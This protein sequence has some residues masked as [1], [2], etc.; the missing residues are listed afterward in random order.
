MSKLKTLIWQPLSTILT[1]LIPILILQAPELAFAQ[2]ESG[3]DE[4]ADAQAEEPEDSDASMLDRIVVTASKR[5]ETL[6]D[7][8]ISMTVVD[9][10]MLEKGRGR[11]LQDMQQLVPNFSMDR[12]G[13]AVLTIRGVGGGGRNIGFDPRAGVYLDGVYIGQAQ[14]LGMPLFDIEQVEVLRGPQGYLFGRN[15]VS[16]AV[17][18]TTRA[19]VS[20]LES[21]VRV[22]GG[23]D[24]TYEGYA[25]VSG[26]ISDRARVKVAASYETRDGYARNLF[27]GED[28]DDLERT[29]LRAQLSVD[30]TQ[31]LS[32]NLY[33]DY[34][35]TEEDNVLGQ[36]V[37]DFFD[38]PFE[39]SLNP[40]GLLPP[41]KVD[42]NTTP[43]VD[44]ELYGASLNLEYAFDGGH[45]L[46]SISAYRGIEQQRQNDTDY[47]AN[48][49]LRI[50]FDDEFDQFSQEIR[51]ASPDSGRLRYLGGLYFLHEDAD[52]DRRATI[53]QDVLTLVPLPPGAPVPFAPFGPAFGLAPGAVVPAIA[54]VETDNFSIFGSLEYDLIES[55]TLN[56][57]LRYTHEEKDL[58]FTLDG[59]QS[60]GFQIGNLDDFRDDRTEDKIDPS[61]SLTWAV[62]DQANIYAKYAR[63][64]K[65]GGWNIDFL[66]V[67][68][69]ATGFDFDS[70]TVDS[71]EIGVKG[72][73]ANGRIRYDLAGFYNEFDDFQ[74]FQF[75]PLGGGAAVLQLRNAAKV[76]TTGIDGSITWL[77]ARGVRLT[78]NFGYVDAEFDRFP[79]GGPDGADLSGNDVPAPDFTAALIAELDFPGELFAGQFSLYAEYSFRDSY[80]SGPSNDPTFERIDSRNLVNTRL[81]YRHRGGHLG[82]GLWVRNLFDENFLNTRG[83]DFI[84]NQFV[85]FGEPRSYGIELR[86]DY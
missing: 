78:G 73:A 7:V 29:S 14:S 46:T 8:P 64:F 84:G 59:S 63:G 27:N 10:D 48:D 5:A 20:E 1:V 40:D 76:E 66:N 41:R 24:G 54:N 25:I 86:Y 35:D 80:F 38:T 6:E 83:R 33:V 65:S 2:S 74:V 22:T 49:L 79:N 23:N 34:T 71:Y 3:A 26:P 82:A 85:Q 15:T 16:G 56:V 50:N 57:G 72:L 62:T 12:A 13:T 30:L 28:L 43:F 31:R 67:G 11:T 60:G 17:N 51:F 47:S 44:N 55:L 42:F 39:N 75:V 19:P 58:R 52:T 9:R 68:Q 53:G 37:T 81:S 70:E 32:A 18:I 4:P 61:V 21:S 45:R 69:I 36:P 77:A